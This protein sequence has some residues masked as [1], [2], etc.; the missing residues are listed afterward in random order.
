[1][2]MI[3]RIAETEDL[4]GCVLALENSALSAAYF[5]TEDSRI[6]AVKEAIESGNTYGAFCG[7]ECVGFVYVIDRGAF[8]AFHYIHL[9]TVKECYRGKGIGK[10]LLE[11]VENLLFRTRDR[12]FLVVGDYNPG[13]RAFYEKSGYTCVGTIPDLYRDGMNEHI[14]MKCR[15]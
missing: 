12:I 13:A 5:Q 2:D 11:Y 8:H 1:M 6:N 10:K 9:L 4:K 3:I 7:E 15:G 14:M